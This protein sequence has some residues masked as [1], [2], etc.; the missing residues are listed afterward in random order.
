MARADIAASQGPLELF[1][2][3]CLECTLSRAARKRLNTYVAE[4][5]GPRARI[6]DN[7]LYDRCEDGLVCERH[8]DVGGGRNTII[9]TDGVDFS[10]I[11]RTRFWRRN[12]DAL[13]ALAWKPCANGLKAKESFR[14][15]IT[16]T[17]FCSMNDAE[18]FNRELTHIAHESAR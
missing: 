18:E 4:Q 12:S 6:V 17:I 5:F 14:P 7:P 1:V 13:I 15:P 8:G 11:D 2:M 16:R 3:P 10:S 9:D